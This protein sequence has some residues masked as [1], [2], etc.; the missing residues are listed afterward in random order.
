M[1]RARNQRNSPYKGCQVVQR[2]PLV[3]GDFITPATMARGR[4]GRCS[5]LQDLQ[6]CVTPQV[7]QT[8]N[9]THAGL[10]RLSYCCV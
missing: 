5:C 1:E 4:A 6:G 8:I 2:T 9:I 10:L 3:H 7:W